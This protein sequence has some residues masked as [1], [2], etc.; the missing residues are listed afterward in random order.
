MMVRSVAAINPGVCPKADSAK[1]TRVQFQKR[2]P[3][4]ERG[5]YPGVKGNNKNNFGNFFGTLQLVLAAA[6]AVA[7][8][9]A[10]RR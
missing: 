5:Q 9:I 6:E 8:A 10:G 1:G 2:P 4:M 3:D 7:A